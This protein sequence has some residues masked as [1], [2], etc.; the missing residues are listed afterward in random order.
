VKSAIIGLD[1]DNTIIKYDDLFHSL[2]RENSLIPADLPKNKT[3]IRD[4]IRQSRGDETW[5]ELQA[6]AYGPRLPEAAIFPGVCETLTRWQDAGLKV[7]IISH[8]TERSSKCGYDL[9]RAAFDFLSQ[10]G[11]MLLIS[12]I[13][14]VNNPDE[15]IALI[16]ERGCRVFID[17]LPKILQH[18]GFPADCGRILFAPAGTETP[19]LTVCMSWSEIIV[20][21]EKLV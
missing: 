10:T 15:K 14:F 3:A 13:N 18:P 8:K 9:R 2:A 5:Q 19:D 20:A 1:L 17:D 6:I 7:V 12:E 4:F 11:I 16:G 21:V